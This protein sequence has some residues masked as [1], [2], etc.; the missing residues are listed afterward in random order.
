VTGAFT[1][2]LVMIRDGSVGLWPGHEARAYPLLDAGAHAE[3]ARR[4]IAAAA[5][6]DGGEPSS[7]NPAG[8]PGWAPPPPVAAHRP[9]DLTVGDANA[10]ASRVQDAG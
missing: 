4:A 7:T 6:E 5:G 1:K 8:K 10:G 2:T 3:E 9:V